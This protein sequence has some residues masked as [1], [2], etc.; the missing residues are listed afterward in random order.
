VF[1][2]STRVC[3]FSSTL[4]GADSTCRDGNLVIY[5][6]DEA[7]WASASWS[8]QGAELLLLEANGTPRLDLVDGRGKAF[9]STA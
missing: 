8:D 7:V 4:S 6:G 1:R 5:S 3:P 2:R 9:W